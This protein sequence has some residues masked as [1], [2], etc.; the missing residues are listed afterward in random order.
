MTICAFPARQSPERYWLG[1]HS[2]VRRHKE[3]LPVRVEHSA[4][5]RTLRFGRNGEL[6]ECP[7]LAQSDI[8][9]A[10]TSL[11]GYNQRTPTDLKTLF[12]AASPGA[13]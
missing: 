8:G 9:E 5:C 3:E 7:D 4:L 12:R 6:W 1:Q 10:S 2:R 11:S 13:A